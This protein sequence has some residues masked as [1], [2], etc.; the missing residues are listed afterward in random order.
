MLNRQRKGWAVELWEPG[1]ARGDVLLGDEVCKGR[2]EQGKMARP[3]GFEPP[4]NGFGSHYSIRL[5][6]GRVVAST[7]H[8]QYRDG[9]RNH[10]RRCGRAFYPEMQDKSAPSGK[11]PWTAR[12]TCLRSY[13]V[14]A[15]AGSNGQILILDGLR[16]PKQSCPL[17]GRRQLGDDVVHGWIKLR[18]G[19]SRGTQPEDLDNVWINSCLNV[20]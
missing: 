18:R 14:M 13:P 16:R 7:R 1:L 8:R 5:S 17:I 20:T 11:F 15:V 10:Q 19:I 12:K 6:Y 2:R 4:T 9:R 3:E